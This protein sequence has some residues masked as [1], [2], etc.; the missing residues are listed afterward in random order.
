MQSFLENDKCM[1]IIVIQRDKFNLLLIF[2]VIIISGN[3]AISFLFGKELIYIGTLAL[4]IGYWF[5]KPLR[6]NKYYFFIFSIFAIISLI[7][8]LMFGTVVIIASLGFLIKLSIAILAVSLIPNFNSQYVRVLYILALIG[9]AFYIPVQLG[10]DLPQLLSPLQIP[11]ESEITHIGIH[12]FHNP[13]EQYRNSG[14]FWEPGAF[15]GYLVLAILFLLADKN[16]KPVKEMT[17]LTIALLTTQ[18]TTGYL[19][20]F[21]AFFI[22]IYRNNLIKNKYLRL[23]FFPILLVG[24]S[25]SSYIFYQTAPF[26]REKIDHQ[27]ESSVYQTGNYR[28]NRIG[29]FSS[30][31]EDIQKSPLFGW[32]PRHAT[33]GEQI[34]ELKSQGQGN[35]LSGFALQFGLVGLSIFFYL[36]YL[37][38]RRHYQSGPFGIIATS[39]VAILLVG[40]QFL[41][42][43]LFMTLMFI[44]VA[45]RQM[46][47]QRQSVLDIKN[48]NYAYK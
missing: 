40:E 34:I 48:S 8:V 14:M 29:N 19:A 17:V 42:F 16:N 22:Y 3:P 44:G 13:N 24:F 26:L 7:H 9:L 25:S 2:L 4:F 37:G 21:I 36:T 11:M 38:F 5:I 28:I 20:F 23:L 6:L 30:D 35:G 46:P 41:G 15:A 18:S 1:K 31:L 39:V 43:P 33:R 45:K 32:S 12:N 10:I 27:W 47:V